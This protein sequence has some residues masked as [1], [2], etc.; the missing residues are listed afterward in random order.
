MQPWGNSFLERTVL[1]KT[2]LTGKPPGCV[3]QSACRHQLNVISRCQKVQSTWKT[4]IF[5]SAPAGCGSGD[6]EFM[7]KLRLDTS[8]RRLA[9]HWVNVDADS[10]DAHPSHCH[11]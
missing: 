5:S 11:G 2:I 4:A 8:H 3:D 1:R 10:L 7:R 9:V 6:K